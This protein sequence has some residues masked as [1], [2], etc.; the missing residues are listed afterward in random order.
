[1]MTHEELLKEAEYIARDANERFR[2]RRH[3]RRRRKTLAP[4]NPQPTTA[5]TDYKC[6]T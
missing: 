2:H 4:M 3:C 1:M 5:P 6:G